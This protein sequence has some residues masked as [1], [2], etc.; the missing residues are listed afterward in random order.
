MIAVKLLSLVVA[1]NATTS[2]KRIYRG[3]VVGICVLASLFKW[4]YGVLRYAPN[5]NNMFTTYHVKKYFCCDI[6]VNL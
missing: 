1:L 3:L 6:A 4:Y 5:K 2:D